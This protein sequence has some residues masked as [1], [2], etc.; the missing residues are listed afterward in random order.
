MLA[1]E[2]ANAGAA[3]ASIAMISTTDVNRQMPD[4]L[5]IFNEHCTLFPNLNS[6]TKLT[7]SRLS[8]RTPAGQHHPDSFEKQL[9]IQPQGP[10]LD[11]ANVEPD[12]L[13]EILNPIPSAYLP[14]TGHTR[15]D[16]DPLAMPVFVSC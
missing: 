6:R 11:V 7:T 5:L 14:Q 9:D 16:A 3:Q 10:F 15:L 8:T 13:V 12:D 2:S 4:S 1:E